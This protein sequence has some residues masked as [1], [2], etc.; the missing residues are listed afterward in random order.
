[1]KSSSQTSHFKT[2]DEHIILL[3][4]CI[5]LCDFSN[6]NCGTISERLVDGETEYSSYVI[7]SRHGRK[8]VKDEE[9]SQEEALVLT[10][11]NWYLC[12]NLLPVENLL[13][14]LEPEDDVFAADILSRKLRDIHTVKLASYL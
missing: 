2:I 1:M 11:I 8:S 12:T 5:G 10:D 7:S 6:I 14:D 13:F 4:I 9:N 3:L